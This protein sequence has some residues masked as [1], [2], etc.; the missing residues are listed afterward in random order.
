MVIR[1]SKGD[2]LNLNNT[3]NALSVIKCGIGWDINK[4]P[5]A[6]Y[7]LDFSILLLD[8][9]GE[10]A[11]ER[12]FVFYN[13]PSDPS[14]SVVSSGDNK[15][16]E[17]EGYDES[18]TV[19]LAAVPRNVQS[20]VLTVSIDQFKERGQNFGQVKNAICDV[21]NDE[22]NQKLIHYDLTEDMSTGT[23]VVV[24]QFER[25]GGSW[26]FIALGS[27]VKGGMPEILKKYGVK[28]E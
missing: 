9:N 21:L 24:C 3:A 19:K 10:L 7:D 28:F 15:T 17:G 5:A 14:G 27:S 23:G 26:R 2:T 16:G 6:P 18:C 20:I 8:D 12:N 13:N 11:D 25:E 4:N 22:T 1:L